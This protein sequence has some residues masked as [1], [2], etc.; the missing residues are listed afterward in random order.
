MIRM[1]AK[2][3]FIFAMLMVASF[4][5]FGCKETAVE[6]E[7]ISFVENSINILVGDTVFPEVK[8]LPSYATDKSYTL[9]SGD[10]TAL[11]VDG[12][13]VIG[14]KAA[15]GVP[16]KVVSNENQNLNDVITVNILEQTTDLETPEGNVS[17]NGVNFTFNAVDGASS[18]MLKITGEG[19]N[20]EIDI[21]NN[22]SYS[23]ET[24][25]NKLGISLKDKVYKYSVKAVG[26][27][28]VYNSSPYTPEVGYV[29]ISTVS[30]VVLTGENI[31][32]LSI[33]NVLKYEVKIKNAITGAE[34][35]REVE[36][37]KASANELAFGISDVIDKQNGGAYSIEI[38]ALKDNYQGEV[39]AE[40]I[41]INSSEKF[42]F[43]SLGQVQNVKINNRVISWNSVDNA[44]VYDVYLY[45]DGTAIRGYSNL[46]QNSQM[47]EQVE[48]GEYWCEVIARS[49]NS[50]VID[51]SLR[52]N[53]LNFKVLEAPTVTANNN[54]ISWTQNADAQGYL[55]YVT[56]D[57][58]E[59]KKFVLG[60]ILDVSNYAAGEYS[61]QVECYGNGEGV[62]SSVK[63][64]QIDWK[65]LGQVGNAKVNN[66]ILSWEDTDANTLNTYRLTIEKDGATV[67]D[68][69]LNSTAL[70]AN[71]TQNGQTFAYDLSGQDFEVGE[72]I[73]KIYNLG[74]NA[75]FDAKSAETKLWKLADSE[76]TSLANG[77]LSVKSVER[78]SSYSI[79][80]YSAT[81][82][83][84]VSPIME[85]DVEN[86]QAT[87]RQT[88]LSAGSYVARVFAY[89]TGEVFDADN[90]GNTAV[91]LSFMKLSTPTMQLDKSA[92]EISVAGYGAEAT[93]QFMENRTEKRLSDSKYDLSNLPAGEYSYK[94]KQL[95]DNLRI[96]DSD[97]TVDSEVI[98]V[99]QIVKPEMSFNKQ[100]LVFNIA[101]DDIGYL[102]GYQLVVGESN[103]AVA[104]G[105]ANASSVITSAGVYNVTLT[106]IPNTYSNLFVIGETVTMSVE[107]LD[108]SA[109]ADI[110]NGKLVITP[111]ATLTEASYSLKLKIKNLN[112]DE[113][114][115]DNFVFKAGE[116]PRFEYA[117]Y[118]NEYNI[119]DIS[120]AAGVKFFDSEDTYTLYAT[121]SNQNGQIVAS[122][123]QETDNKIYVL[124]KVSAISKDE[125]QIKFNPVANATQYMAYLKREDVTHYFDVTSNC[126]IGSEC[127]LSIDNLLQLM[128]SENIAYVEDVPYTIGFVAIS[129]NS[130]YVLSKSKAQNN[131]QFEF[132]LKPEISV[133]EGENNA[134]YLVINTS[135]TKPSHY[136]LNIAQGE[137]SSEVEYARITENIKI[138]LS[139]FTQLLSG[140]IN[141]QIKAK[142]Q[143][144]DYFESSYSSLAMEKLA[145]SQV[146]AQ[147]GVLVWD[148][149]QNAKQYNLY[150]TQSGD[151]KKLELTLQ[152]ENFTIANGKCNYDFVDLQSGL[153]SVYLQVDA[154]APN[155]GIYLNSSNGQTTYDIYK[156]SNI[157]MSVVNGK[158]DFEFKR[159]D[160]E[161]SSRVELTLDGTTVT[162]DFLADLAE[163]AG[164]SDTSKVIT[165]EGVDILSYPSTSV[166]TKEKL[167]IRYYTTTDN[168]LNSQI[169]YKDIAGLLTPTGLEI[170]TTIGTEAGSVIKDVLE[171]IVWSNPSGNLSYVG[172]YQVVIGYKDE[173]YEYFTTDNWLTMPKFD[174]QNSNGTYDEGETE[175]G[176]GTYTIKVRS[177]AISQNNSYVVNSQ[178]CEAIE[179]VVLDD[180][181]GLSTKDGNFTW[182]TDTSAEYFIVRVY[183]IGG[184]NNTLIASAQSRENSFDLT[185][186]NPFPNGTYML[187]VQA[188]HDALRVLSS[189]ESEPLQVIR[190]PQASGYYIKEGAVWIKTH[191][192]ANSLEIYL[193]K[194][195]TGEMLLGEDGKPVKF[196][197]SNTDL[198][199]YNEFVEAMTDWSGSTILDTYEAD[200]FWMDIKYE[201]KNGDITLTQAV[202]DGYLLDIKLIGNSAT[203][204]AIISGQTTSDVKN[205][206]FDD[207]LVKLEEP[208]VGVNATIIGQVDF[209][210]ARDYTSLTYYINGDA[211]LK[212]AYLY[213]INIQGDKAYKMYVAEIFNQELFDAS[214]PSVTQ[215]DATKHN[216]KHFTYG[217]YCF[218]V[219][220][221]LSID[222]TKDEYFYYSTDGVYST[223]KFNL[224]GSFIVTARLLGDDTHFAQSNL[225]E[226]VNIYR[227]SILSLTVTDGKIAWKNLANEG[228]YPIY[229]ITFTGAQ[230]YDLVLYNPAVQDLDTVKSCLDKS[231]TYVFDTITYTL[232]DEQIVYQNLANK[233]AECAGNKLGGTFTANIMAYNTDKTSTN[234]VLAQGTDPKVITVLSQAE[235]GITDGELKWNQVYVTTSNGQDYIT[236][237]ELE[238]LDNAGNKYT[239]EL[240]DGD[241][242]L[243]N[244]IASFELPQQ[245]GEGEEVFAFDLT[246][247]YTFKLRA[248][249]GNGTA[250]VNSVQT[251]TNEV[252]LLPTLTAEMKDGVVTWENSTTNSVEVVVSYTSGKNTIIYK[253]TVNSSTFDLPRMFTD[254][255]GVAGEFTSAYDYT[256]KI[257]LAGASGQLNG[258]YSN[259]ISANRLSSIVSGG[260]TTTNGTLTWT[261]S[262]VEGSTYKVFYTFGEATSSSVWIS[263]DMLETAEF[264]FEGVDSGLIT[265]YVQVFNNAY[266]KSFASEQIELFKLDIPTNIKF[267]DGTTTILWDK[268]LD[269]N[270]N[271]VNTYR[272]KVSEEGQ[273]PFEADCDTNSWQITGVTSNEFSISIKAIS[274]VADSGLINSEYGEAVTMTQPEAVDGETFKFNAE[275]Q[276]FEWKAITD[277]QSADRYYIGYNYY[278]TAEATFERRE[279]LASSYEMIDGEK[280]YYFKPYEIGIYRQIY[281]QVK[282]A[283]SLA[284]KATYCVENESNYVL[285]FNI[286]K[287]GN[288]KTNAYQ[289]ENEQQLRNIKYFPN[290]NYKLLADIELTTAGSITNES[291]MFGGKLDGDNHYI[292]GY[293]ATTND[294]LSTHIGLFANCSNAEF[295]NIKISN[296]TISGYINS[297]SLYLGVL[298]GVAQNCQF[299]NIVITSGTISAVKDNSKGYQGDGLNIYIGGMV[300]YATN[301]TTTNC[302]V[303]INSEWNSVS[304]SVTSNASSNVYVGGI[305]G[306]YTGGSVTGSDARFNLKYT[307]LANEVQLP[308]L[309]TGLISGHC[310]TQ[311]TITTCTGT[312]YKGATSTKNEEITENIGKVG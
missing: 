171:K 7:S 40:N 200:E 270:G 226:P 163:Q 145:S 189:D 21:G 66:K 142:A 229:I 172:E 49:N 230:Q 269:K 51:A 164:E 141:V 16:L 309:Y 209:E 310:T 147:N 33:G 158:I 282:R 261:E 56:G 130:K 104:N 173:E 155:G 162:V 48:A 125:Q 237:Y 103:V 150:Y 91:T 156:M 83:K 284:S 212:G 95:G 184:E 105:V 174:D 232:D 290:A 273:E 227:Y 37:S 306:E 192:F 24:L 67:L 123:E 146:L 1:K 26:D 177:L 35:V 55:V 272:V 205:S 221:G 41:F 50:N 295:K 53:K 242:K 281:V 252:A 165:K 58:T 204:G 138:D 153:V 293:I 115:L 211:S 279:N 44:E 253:T 106:A 160:W 187:T 39:E 180:P 276:R 3:I 175:F 120:N 307:L 149:V 254:I 62:I 97:F 199:E 287:A 69:T 77:R 179:V 131:Y 110:E 117:I 73:V 280:I 92:L 25:E 304:V 190:L 250:Y 238:I 178:Y 291:M 193:R 74:A 113:L 267:D 132:L 260:L 89:G 139:T 4:C 182:D 302:Q 161:K 247:K 275:L 59:N 82:I 181:E 235:I 57:H 241:Y 140:Q 128:T 144:G 70:G 268:V 186:L 183:L 201:D 234:R 31:K 283:V 168:V 127:L 116:T 185:L 213:E 294:L 202:A 219:L 243:N 244:H 224:C 263:T 8:V 107:K 210:T 188:M 94:V 11:K 20:A 170:S 76:V 152:S 308:N 124:D 203:K 28:H 264:D 249:A 298:A 122:N 285:N 29:S 54:V 305:A 255:N 222:F 296:F 111:K 86:C 5:L 126:T 102:S 215:D 100:A 214:V 133:I 71:Y 45:R 38:T 10:I 118:D 271:E 246:A 87:L 90:D 231:K 121:I 46:T 218:N 278:K 265:A 61:I 88:E 299:D 148:E 220:D 258:F 101:C 274:K 166:L 176:A 208:I 112:N 223:I 81:D 233:I 119:A 12:L 137:I 303:A 98:K 9:L 198:T 60:N 292:N 297:Q 217:G 47:F 78:A 84:F 30:N 99:R 135:N 27:G 196:E 129:S 14:L 286:F 2:S 15:R 266:F 85:L 197:V 154:I 151:P 169:E 109:T 79:K 64:A 114:I 63:S 256:I 68:Q 96:L 289:I 43:K 108:G 143:T 17:F 157:K 312:A 134:K 239:L 167:G 240:K 216:L 259:E 228:D 300:G 257:R 194:A 75:V 42:E 277:E 245:F 72:H 34:V 52:S 301:C 93:F 13:K 32:F 23:W 262:S 251:A 19:V 311:P 80:I 248:L 195:S 207:N 159:T 22:T 225:C 288:G 236:N 6:A 65:I 136:E 191:C 206:K 18:Y 36:S